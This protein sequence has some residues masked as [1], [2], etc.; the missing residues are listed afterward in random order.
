MKIKIAQKMPL[1]FVAVGQFIACHRV[2]TNISE[3]NISFFRDLVFRIACEIFIAI[4]IIVQ[5]I[6]CVGTDYLASLKIVKEIIITNFAEGRFFAVKN[7][8]ADRNEKFA[9]RP[10]RSHNSPGTMCKILAQPQNE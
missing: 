10:H 3:R 9:S 2:K 8:L 1:L 6:F 7:R 4:K 5:S